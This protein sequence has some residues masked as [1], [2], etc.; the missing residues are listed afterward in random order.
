MAN[1]TTDLSCIG[2][3]RFV[4]AEWMMPIA[5]AVRG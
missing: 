4:E 5:C 3:E 2:I 1:L